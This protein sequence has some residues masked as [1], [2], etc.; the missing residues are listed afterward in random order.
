MSKKRN[1]FDSMDSYNPLSLDVLSD[2]DKLDSVLKGYVSN[3]DRKRQ[4]KVKKKSDEVI[5]MI[6]KAIREASEEVVE[7]TYEFEKPSEEVEKEE[8]DALSRI[9]D[10]DSSESPSTETTNDLPKMIYPDDESS[11]VEVADNQSESDQTAIDIELHEI[12]NMCKFELRDDRL[13]IYDD[14]IGNISFSTT[15][16]DLY[17]GFLDVEGIGELITLTFYN[18]LVHSTP[19]LITSVKLLKEHGIGEEFIDQYDNNTIFIRFDIFGTDEDMVFGFYVPELVKQEWYN[20]M[21]ALVTDSDATDSIISTMIRI[22]QVY[23]KYDFMEAASDKDFRKVKDEATIEK[24]VDICNTW[25]SDNDESVESTRKGILPNNYFE[26]KIEELLGENIFGGV[27]HD[28]EPFLG[29][30]D[31]SATEEE[32]AAGSGDNE[33]PVQEEQE[34]IQ[35]EAPQESDDEV[36]C[37]VDEEE[38]E[39]ALQSIEE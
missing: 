10:G 15:T 29:D 21:N 8:K 37:E 4:K 33:P 6:G 18:V 27:D 24:F 13:W 2:P 32:T 34:E 11:E 20:I 3:S 25:P 38:I 17:D 14:Y 1:K 30:D 36:D 7:T 9:M 35:E 19:D 26:E 39:K 16:D 31:L 12:S 5:D 22:N 28:H 23:E